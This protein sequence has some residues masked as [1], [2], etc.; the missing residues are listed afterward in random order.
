MSPKGASLTLRRTGDDGKRTK[1]EIVFTSKRLPSDAVA[2]GSVRPSERSERTSTV[3][4]RGIR[5]Y[6]LWKGEFMHK[7]LIIIF[8]GLALLLGGGTA[9]AQEKTITSQTKETQT[10]KYPPYP[11][12]W[13]WQV[14]NPEFYVA[15]SLRTYLLDNG[16]VLILYTKQKTLDL[17][18]KTKDKPGIK[19]GTS[20]DKKMANLYSKATGGIAVSGEVESRQVTLFSGLTVMEE[21]SNVQLMRAPEK[22]LHLSNGSAAVRLKSD[23]D[24]YGQ[25]GELKDKTQI[26]SSCFQYHDCYI[27]PAKCTFHHNSSKNGGYTIVRKVVFILLDKPKRWEGAYYNEVDE[28]N[29]RDHKLKIQVEPLVGGILALEDGSFLVVNDKMGRIIRFNPDFTTGSPLL[30]K[31][32][33]VFDYDNDKE[34]DFVKSP[35][36]MPKLNSKDYKDLKGKTKMQEVLD[37]LYNYLI[38]RSK[39]VNNG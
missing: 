32:I 21:P 7:K 30:N 5:T 28:C 22:P 35:L 13:D 38:K 3:L 19:S 11:D 1:K 17:K 31:K 26:V 12:V 37:D 2:W 25:S 10:A 6:R 18:K 27:G 34:L 8:I 20:V 33:F 9:R 23:W 36:F 15:G 29:E 16:D 14:P 4:R 24:N 39:G